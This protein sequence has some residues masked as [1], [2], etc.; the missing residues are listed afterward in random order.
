MNDM[1]A[2]KKDAEEYLQSWVDDSSPIN[3]RI[4]KVNKNQYLI[5]EDHDRNQNIPCG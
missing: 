4:R 1:Y 5:T 2:T 3:L